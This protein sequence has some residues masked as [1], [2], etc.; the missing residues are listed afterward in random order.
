VL[1]LSDAHQALYDRAAMLLI[2]IEQALRAQDQRAAWTEVRGEGDRVPPLGELLAA[3]KRVLAD[4]G[5]LVPAAIA[6]QAAALA[7]QLETYDDRDALYAAARLRWWPAFPRVAFER[8][9]LAGSHQATL[10]LLR[11][12][13]ADAD[14]GLREVLEQRAVEQGA[15]AHSL[16]R[17]EALFSR[18]ETRPEA[19]ALYLCIARSGNAIAARGGADASLDL[20]AAVVAAARCLCLAQV[21]IG[22][23]TPDAARELHDVIERHGSSYGRAIEAAVRGLGLRRLPPRP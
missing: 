21:R 13:P 12:L 14:P 15:A 9:S 19:F 22:E 6:E 2:R 23:L 7:A 5:E 3:A 8:A 4:V 18:G 17:A 16:R 10:A 11:Q 20:Q 1:V